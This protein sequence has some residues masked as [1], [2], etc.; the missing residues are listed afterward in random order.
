MQRK[1]R[2]RKTVHLMGLP[3][4]VEDGEGDADVPEV[5]GSGLN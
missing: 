1:I 3:P 5:E 4:A 2:E